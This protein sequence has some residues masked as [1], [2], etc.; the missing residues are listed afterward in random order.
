F[1]ELAGKINT[2]MPNYVVERVRLALNTARKAVAGSR[3]LLLG[4][5]YKANV[6]DDRESPSYVLW[7]LLEAQGAHV[8]YHDPHV[9]VIRPSREHGHFAGN[10]SVNLNPQS[11]ASYDLVLLSTSH[12]A[13]DYGLIAEHAKL[14][15]DTRNAFA[16][17]VKHPQRYFKA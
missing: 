11:I 5:A 13:V 3:I 12:Q 1:I 6:D 2:A 15:V 10:K 14:L 4:I 9:P 8:E 17:L 16:G 7:E